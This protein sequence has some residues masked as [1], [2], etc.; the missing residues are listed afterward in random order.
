MIHALAVVMAAAWKG[1][2]MEATILYAPRDI[3]FEQRE[4]DP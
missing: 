1:Y 2:E 4:D 3:R